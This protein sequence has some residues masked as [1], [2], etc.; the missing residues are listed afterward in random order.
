MLP[1]LVPGLILLLISAVTNSSPQ[2]SADGVI[3]GVVVTQ[4]G[5]PLQG[6]RVYLYQ[7]GLSAVTVTEVDGT[8]RIRNAS[9][10]PHRIFAYKED[11][12][13]RTPVWSFFS[14]TVGG[15]Q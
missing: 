10:G 13:F 1:R 14:S 9:V 5:V 6:A 7:S 12:G 11:D 3:E 8:F 2:S 4:S 15:T